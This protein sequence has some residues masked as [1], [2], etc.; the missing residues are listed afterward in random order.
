MKWLIFLLVLTSC[1]KE[2]QRVDVRLSAKCRECAIEYTANGETHRDTMFWIIT[3][4]GDTTPISSAWNIA[5]LDGD[6][7]FSFQ[8]CPLRTDT[9]MDVRVMATGDIET[10]S[11]TV[12]DGGC[13]Y[14][15]Q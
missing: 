3:E 2:P 5:F 12:N 15:T 4:Y 14:I 7:G 13:A 6:V 9:F 11:S 1:A 8:A 10:I